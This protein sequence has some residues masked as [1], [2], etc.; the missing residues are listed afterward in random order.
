MKM[1]CPIPGMAL[2]TDLYQITMAY[3]YW[4]SGTAEK[5]AVFHLFFRKTHSMA[6]LPWL[7]GW[8]MCWS[9]YSSFGFRR[10]IFDTLAV[11]KVAM[12]G[13]C[14]M[15]DFF[16]ISGLLNSGVMLMPCRKELWF[17]PKNLSCACKAPFSRRSW[18]K[19][20]CS[21]SSTFSR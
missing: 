7:A 14:S 13:N 19:Q 15:K 11:S 18:L 16:N 20:H 2:L 3:G 9:I 1:H 8:L 4:R 12:V 21:T 17:F 5:E 10:A 6:A